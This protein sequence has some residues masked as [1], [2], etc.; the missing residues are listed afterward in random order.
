MPHNPTFTSTQRL[1][2][3]VMMSAKDSRKASVLVQYFEHLKLVDESEVLVVPMN[4]YNLFLA[5]P[6]L[7]VKNLEFDWTKGR[8]TD[9]RP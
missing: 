8:L 1:N 2:G 3:Q 9:L 6:W 7:K 4:A 5:L